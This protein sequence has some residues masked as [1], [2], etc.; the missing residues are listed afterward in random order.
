M[1]VGG[2]IPDTGVGTLGFPGDVKAVIETSDRGWVVTLGASPR[3]GGEVIL[4]VLVVAGFIVGTNPEEDA[5]TS[6]AI[7]EPQMTLPG[8]K[9]GL[10]EIY[11]KIKA[12]A[13]GVS[14]LTLSWFLSVWATRH[15]PLV[16]VTGLIVSESSEA[17]VKT[18]RSR[19]EMDSKSIID[20]GERGFISAEVEA[21][22]VQ[23]E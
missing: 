10:N 1:S 20:P 4:L 15:G 17:G 2:L 12:G 13:V 23:V 18:S 5:I 22:I 8:I 16:L 7:R 14:N 21:P 3:V 19:D 11:Q 9:S 6:S